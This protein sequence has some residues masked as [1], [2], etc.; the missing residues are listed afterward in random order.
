VLTRE[1]IASA[2]LFHPFISSRL[3]YNLARDVSRRW[4][5]F[6]TRVKVHEE[7]TRGTEEESEGV[8][9]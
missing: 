9:P 6:V 8:Q 5:D 4:V 3:F 1:A 2:T 7:L